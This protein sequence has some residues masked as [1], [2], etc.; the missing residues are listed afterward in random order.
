MKYSFLWRLLLLLLATSVIVGCGS[1]GLA[2]VDQSEL[3]QSTPQAPTAIPTVVINERVADGVTLNSFNMAGLNR[4]QLREILITYTLP[5]R[6]IEIDAGALQERVVFKGLKIDEEATSDRL[7]RA[8]PNSQIEPV[9]RIDANEVRS[10]L[11]LLNDKVRTLTTGP[12]TIVAG[13]TAYVRQFRA[14]Q[15]Q[16]ID[17]D[18]AELLVI[19]ALD[20]NQKALELPIITDPERVNPTAEQ[21]QLAVNE[22][23]ASWPGVVGIYVYDIDNDQVVATLNEMSV[24]SGASVMKVAILLNAYANVASFDDEVKEWMRQ[25]IVVSDNIAANR[26]LAISVGGLS[27]EDAYRGTQVM[28]EMFK[29]LGLQ[30]TYQNLPYEARDYLIGLLNYDI[31]RGPKIEGPPP[32]TDADPMLRT[33]PAEM[34]KVFLEIYRCS[35][36]SGALL[37]LYPETLTAERCGEMITLMKRNGD[38]TRMMSGLPEGTVAARKSGWI[39]DMQADVGIVTTP[40]GRN[41]LMAIYVY[42]PITAEVGNLPDEV[43]AE[44]IGGFARLIYS[45]FEP[46]E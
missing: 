31:A 25:M 44:A 43:A 36:G 17:V 1:S 46:L 3:N 29:K 30:F 45:A 37:E 19:D 20:G 18:A 38:F 2:D 28:N 14:I 40:S 42:R 13:D 15:G 4:D 24:F 39:E 32:H 41:F 6:V 12:A 10:Q 23:A 21:L 33:T 35:Q 11:I 27:T 26:M 34:S 16:S 5:S 9:M 7:L 22:M 8:E